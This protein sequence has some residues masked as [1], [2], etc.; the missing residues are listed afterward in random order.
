MTFKQRLSGVLAAGAVAM[1]F[2][3]PLG[4]QTSDEM[5]DARLSVAITETIAGY[6][7]YGDAVV[8]IGSLW[9][10]VYGCI[11]RF[12]FEEG[13]FVPYLA[14]RLEVIDDLT[15]LI[16]LRQ[17]WVRHN[18]DPVVAAD[19]VHSID[20]MRNDPNSVRQFVV[21]PIESAEV[22][23]DHTV[24]IVTKEPMATL[25]DNLSLVT[26]TSKSVFDEFGPQVA[27]REHPYGAG[28]YRLEEIAVGQHM[29]LERVDDHPMVSPDNPKQI[30]YRIIAE[31]EARVTA[32][33]NGEVQ[34]AQGIPPQL[35][36]RT[37]DLPN[38]RVEFANSVEMMFLA[39]NP[40]QHPWDVLEAR[41]AVAHAI[42]REAIVQ[43]LL[44]GQATLLNGAVGEGQFGFDP[45]YRTPYEYDPARA[46][47]LLES[48][49]L[50][51]VEIDFYTPV[52]RYVQDRQVAEAMVPM[53]EE[54]GFT[55]N[56]QTPEWAS[57]WSN[58]QSGGVPFYYMGRG[59]ML[60]PS[61]ALHQYFRTDGS[62]R[63]EF[64]DPE[65]D[66]LLDAERR[67]FD[68]D[69]RLEKMRLAIAGLTEAAPAHFLWLHEMAWGVAE[70][71]D[72]TPRPADRVDGWDIHI[73]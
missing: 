72:Y 53:L 21:D 39:M 36:D 10:K 15:W 51:G 35:V 59:Q 67:E 71:V 22:L 43:A 1:S 14:E 38:A 6:N 61:R 66:A 42:N 23:D 3:A 54:A 45:D 56:L 69:A 9:C 52:G 31:P 2:V 25:D 46:R 50:V 62:P 68:P 65:I 16:H 64:S 17:N 73:R 55:V 27:D 5:T 32:L 47:E 18:G 24:R 11:T 12:N 58:V 40:S 63:L 19:V 29:I 44:A 20:R 33:A 37:E 28:P 41:Q 8:L 30:M 26:V 34:I 48:A 4:A 70:G 57:L 7:P 13:R 49:G 60:D